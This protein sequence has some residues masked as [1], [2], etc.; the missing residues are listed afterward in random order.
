MRGLIRGAVAVVDE[1]KYEKT[2]VSKFRHNRNAAVAEMEGRGWELV[3]EDE[4]RLKVTLHFQ[5]QKKPVNRLLVGGLA[6]VMVT[7]FAMIGILAALEDDDEKPVASPTTA[8]ADDATDVVSSE[9]SVEASDEAATKPAEPE[10]TEPSATEILTLENDK[11][12]AAILAEP[13]N[14]SSAIAGWVE[15]HEGAVIQFDG[16]IG[17]MGKHGDYDTRYDILVLPGD[18]G[19]QTGIGPSFQFRDVNMSDLHLAGD[20]PEAIG[21]DD[22]LAVTAEVVGEI[23][24]SR[25]NW[26]CLVYLDPISTEVR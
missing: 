25:D 18:D 26:N 11:T 1:V 9:P 7:L 2:S 23:Y 4:G 8:A 19:S 14:C 13:E 10:A 16:S 6:A 20:V 24:P 12:F 3:D 21:V 22:K 17:A 15:E 5:R